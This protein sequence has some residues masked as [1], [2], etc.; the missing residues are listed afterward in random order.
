MSQRV[1]LFPA[2]ADSSGGGSNRPQR[3]HSAA[4]SDPCKRCCDE[5]T[6][7]G[8]TPGEAEGA[9]SVCRGST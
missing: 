5:K 2:E 7:Y 6:D 9:P 4:A 1:L 3:T 8:H